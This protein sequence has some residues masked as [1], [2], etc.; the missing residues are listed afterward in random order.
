MNVTKTCRDIKELNPKAQTA[1]SLFLAECRKQGVDVFITETYRSQARQ[2]YLYEQGRTRPGQ[3]VTWTK[4]SNHTGRMAW[5]I[6]VSP[7][8]ALYDRTTLNKAGVVAKQLGITWGG[9]W[10]TPDKPHFE[11][12]DSWQVPM[13]VLKVKKITITVNGKDRVVDAIEKDGQNYVKL[14]DLEDSSIKV[15]FENKKPTIDTK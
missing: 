14:R 9:A 11:I 5:D 10:K 1:C 4:S 3:V 8:K 13:E 7:P 12:S 6:A 15:G 2:N